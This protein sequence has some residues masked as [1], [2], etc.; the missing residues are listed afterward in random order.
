MS[1]F[2]MREFSEQVYY[3]FKDDTSHY[4]P[5]YD[6]T[7]RTK[8]TDTHSTSFFCW[9]TKN[10]PIDYSPPLTFSHLTDA[11]NAD[12]ATGPLFPSLSDDVI[13]GSSQTLDDGTIPSDGTTMESDGYGVMSD[14]DYSA[15]ASVLLKEEGAEVRVK[16]EPMCE[17]PSQ[18]QQ[19]N[20]SDPGMMNL[21][22]S[23]QE[24]LKPITPDHH[25]P[26]MSDD[27]FQLF[28]RS[29][30]QDH[31]EST[32]DDATANFQNII[33]ECISLESSFNSPDRLFD[34]ELNEISS[35][36]WLGCQ[37]SFPSQDQLVS[38]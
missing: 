1:A 6:E 4:T 23:F 26:Q 27:P 15:L 20:Y 37:A 29:L 38:S 2:R 14:F 8:G 32:S 16:D 12:D 24:E 25:D 19:M 31:T 17:Q 10:D 34:E 35:C 21:F 22:P 30:N 5:A 3:A 11:M 9:S 33:D 13:D 36:R 7:Y 18:Q 28:G